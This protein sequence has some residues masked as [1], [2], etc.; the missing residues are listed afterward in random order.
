G[1]REKHAVYPAIGSAGASPSQP[2]EGVPVYPAAWVSA[3]VTHSDTANAK[4]RPVCT[5]TH[6]IV[7]LSRSPTATS[8]FSTSAATIL[9]GLTRPKVT[10]RTTWAVRERNQ[11]SA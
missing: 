1:T 2:K 5:I 7:K 6:Q 3:H 9:R 10:T 4:R 8:A 11:N